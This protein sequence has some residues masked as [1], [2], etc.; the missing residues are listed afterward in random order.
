[1]K[2]NIPQISEKLNITEPNSKTRY[3]TADSNQESIN[4]VQD[5]INESNKD[6][7]FVFDTIKCAT[8]TLIVIFPLVMSII[9]FSNLKKE[10]LMVIEVHEDSDVLVLTSIN[11]YYQ[12]G[13]NM[14]S[15]FQELELENRSL[16]FEIVHS[17][18]QNDE[19]LL[20]VIDDKKDHFRRV[21]SPT[22]FLQEYENRPYVIVGKEDWS[23][24]ISDV[25][26]VYSVN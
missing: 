25:Y 11:V 9:V 13:V 23:K 6:E 7:N 17:I 4:S 21:S 2:K 8:V 16:E 19:E 18:T 12:F 22:N 5:I 14:A 3:F 24:I 15:S 26:N 1:M 20:I 10:E